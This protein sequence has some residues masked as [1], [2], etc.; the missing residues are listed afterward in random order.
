MNTVILN[1]DTP[2]MV[3]VSAIVP[4]Y[5]SSGTLDKA[6]ES[7]FNQ[8]VA[9][10][11]VF[12]VD[13]ASDKDELDN[14]ER[15]VEKWIDFGLDIKLVI[16]N[17]NMGASYSRNVGIKLST[18]E[19]IA[20]LDSDDVWHP[21]KIR[22][23]YGIM[24]QYCA[25]MCGHRYI[26]N[27]TLETFPIAHVQEIRY[28]P[29]R[30]FRFV[31]GNPF[32]TPTV[33]LRKKGSKLFPENLKRAEDY[34]CWIDNYQRGKVL[35]INEYL[36]GGSKFSYGAGGLSQNVDEMHKSIL[37][38][39]RMLYKLKRVNLLFLY[40]ASLIE[41]FKYF[42]RLIRVNGNSGRLNAIGIGNERR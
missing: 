40:V 16:N 20:F 17:E 25:D 37:L 7:I 19:Y 35:L 9:V 39:F 10:R 29:M 2:E 11:K 30:R 13:D 4:T 36:A 8:T 31:L 22:I 14:I 1:P 28:R 21:D 38:C 3:D 26:P 32:A 34:Y 42:I 5:N 12:V 33:M 18:S 27:L 6:L 23:Q 24:E 41:Q 15:I